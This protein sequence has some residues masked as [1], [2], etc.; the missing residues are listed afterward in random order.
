MAACVRSAGFFWTPHP[1]VP[2]C[3]MPP[4]HT[5]Q[6]SRGTLLARTP[7]ESLRP[8]VRQTTE[9]V[10]EQAQGE[11]R[12]SV[13]DAVRRGGRRTGEPRR[14]GRFSLGH[15]QLSVDGGEQALLSAA[16]DDLATQPADARG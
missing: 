10:N 13:R 8:C 2:S 11:S 3:D 6:L 16:A 1:I 4:L 12:R 9:I 5:A 14:E 7:W 15:R